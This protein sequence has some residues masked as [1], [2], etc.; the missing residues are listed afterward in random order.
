MLKKVSIFGLLAA[1]LGCFSS[2]AWANSLTNVQSSAQ[3]A[4]A[5]GDF[6]QIHQSTNQI[7]LLNL[8]SPLDT[9]MPIT[10][11]PQDSTFVQNAQQTA[12]TLGSGNKVGQSADQ[13]SLPDLIRQ[14][15]SFIPQLFR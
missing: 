3:D 13:S 1:T 5:F 7:N 4:A 6:N 12:E 10:S 8:Q 11:T 14:P 15:A 9:L 2:T